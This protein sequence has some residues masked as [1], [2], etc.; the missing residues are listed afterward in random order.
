M[1]F[2]EH[3][4]IATAHPFMKQFQ[5]HI[6]AGQIAPDVPDAT[7]EVHLKQSGTQISAK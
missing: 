5:Q 3:E 6:E 7:F 4:L 1:T 2:G